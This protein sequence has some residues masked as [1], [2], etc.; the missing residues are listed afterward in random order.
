MNGQPEA[1]KALRSHHHHPAVVICPFT[2]DDAIVRTA[3]QQA[4]ALH[5]RSDLP[6]DPFIQDIVPDDMGPQ[7]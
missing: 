3:E 2:P 7:G 6:L 1:G 4:A 5:P